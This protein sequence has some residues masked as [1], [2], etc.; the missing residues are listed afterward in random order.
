MLKI[1]FDWNCITHSKNKCKFILSIAKCFGRNFIFPFSNAH[2]RDVLVSHKEGNVFFDSDI[3]LLETICGNHYL[4]VENGQIMPMFYKPRDVIEVYGDQLEILQNFELITPEMYSSIK[5]EIKKLL[6]TNVF[7]R[8]QGAAPQNIFSIIDEYISQKLPNHNLNS[9][10]S[11]SYSHPSLSQLIDAELR[12]KSMC[13]IL[14]LFGFRP[15]K[16]DKSLM[17]IDTDATHMFYGMLCDIFV[18]ADKKLA[19]KAKA[20]YQKYNCQTKILHPEELEAFII[21]ELRKENSLIYL[22]EVIDNFGVPAI[23]EDKL[24]YKFLPTQI[25]GMFNTCHKIDESC[26]IKFKHK[27]GLFRYCFNNTPFLFSTEITYFCETIESFLP[28]SEK[29]KFINNYKIPILSGNF[30]M[31]SKAQYI[32]DFKEMETQ[33]IL[34]SDPLNPVPTPMMLVIFG[35]IFEEYIKK[36]E[37]YCKSTIAH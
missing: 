4:R 26:G 2:I 28:D 36:N 27:A 11:M 20:V 18:T 34:L 15:E 6:P 16:K 22:S 13:M 31:T 17:N 30:E 25:F 29:D 19:N 37:Q 23:K 7:K 9:L 33:L 10:M 32:C 1:Y 8:I 14:D 21:D 35:D 5:D 24:C 12:F 3:S